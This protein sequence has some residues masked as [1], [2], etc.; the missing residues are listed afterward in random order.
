MK[1]RLREN[2]YFEMK[3]PLTIF[4]GVYKQFKTT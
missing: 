4:Y 1:D 3:N 2:G